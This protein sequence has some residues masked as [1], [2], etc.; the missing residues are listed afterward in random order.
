MS[1]NEFGDDEKKIA[2]ARFEMGED[3]QAPREVSLRAGIQ[4]NHDG[5]VREAQ[6]QD[7]NK[8]VKSSALKH[9]LSGRRWN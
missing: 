6:T 9:L 1:L 5:A 7:I 3:A 8:D 4:E 2:R